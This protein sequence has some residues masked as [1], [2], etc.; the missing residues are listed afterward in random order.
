MTTTKAFHG[1]AHEFQVFDTKYLG[2]AVRNPTTRFGF[3]STDAE[4]DALHWARKGATWHKEV[5]LYTVEH[6]AD[7]Y[8]DM[9]YD[10]FYYYL[11][12][13]RPSTIDKHRAKWMEQGFHGFR[14]IRDDRLWHCTFDAANLQILEVTRINRY[15]LVLGQDRSPTP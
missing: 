12:T 15:A 7:R 2:M 8:F 10:Q 14:V 6:E 13:A 4:E 11:Q 5:F 3:F 1:S 9:E